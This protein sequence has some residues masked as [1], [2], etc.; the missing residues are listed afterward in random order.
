MNH[1]HSWDL[2]PWYVNGSV[3]DARREGIRRHLAECADCR[4]EVETQRALMQAMKT[5]PNV[6]NMPHGSLQKLWAR[7]DAQPVPVKSPPAWPRSPRLVAAL[8]AAVALQAVLL[9]VLS[10]ALLR[11]HS[12]AEAPAAY[13]TVSSASVPAGAASVR[14]VFSQSMTLGELQALLE[15]THLRIV[16]GPSPDGVFTLATLSNTDDPK[17]ALLGLRAHPAVQFAEPITP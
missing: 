17:Q 2:I 15:R 4:Q 7:I 1:K 3:P 14:A 13:R 10:F 9:G 11:S 8:A 5:R 12:A 6:E 16:N